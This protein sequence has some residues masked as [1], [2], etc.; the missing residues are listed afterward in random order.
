MDNPC[1]PVLHVGTVPVL[2]KRQDI[3]SYL[4]RHFFLSPGF[5]SDYVEDELVKKGIK[6][7]PFNKDNIENDM[8]VVIGNA[9]DESNEEVKRTLEL[10]IKHYYYYDLLRELTL[11]YNSVAICGC[12]GKTTTTALLSHVFDDLV[13]ANYLIGDGTGHAS[14]NNTYFF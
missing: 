12:H 14:K 2:R 7:L 3:C 8:I 4:V 13:G 5:T 11:E 9:F 6:I 10:G 1:I